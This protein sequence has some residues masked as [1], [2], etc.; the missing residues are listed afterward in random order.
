MESGRLIHETEAY[1]T[2]TIRSLSAVVDIEQRRDRADKQDEYRG[3]WY[4]YT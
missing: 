2:K 3:R 1:G 4:G